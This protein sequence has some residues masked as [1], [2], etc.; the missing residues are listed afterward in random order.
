VS[1]PK[2]KPTVRVVAGVPPANPKTFHLDKRAADLIV[3]GAGDPDDLMTTAQ[4]AAWWDVSMIWL[5][6]SRMRGDGPPFIQIAPRH[7]RYKRSHL[8][9][10]LEERM[11]LSTNEY[12]RRGRKRVGKKKHSTE[13]RLDAP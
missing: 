10:W 12:A 6:I 9:A 4:V 13:G 3:Q 7:I 5:H 11:R 2:Q 1:K 8:L